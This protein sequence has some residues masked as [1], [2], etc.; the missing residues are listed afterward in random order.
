MK[1]TNRFFT[2][3]IVTLLLFS[4]KPVSAQD[5]DSPQRP[6]YITATTFHWNMDYKDFDMDTWKAVEKEYL[7][8][9]VKKN[10]YIMGYSVYLHY[11]TPD[12]SELVFVNVYGSWDD[13]DKAGDRNGELIR[14]GW[15]DE[16][17]RREFFQK[18]NAY[19]ADTHSDEIYAPMSGAK[20][21]A[22]APT[23]DVICY[24]RTSHFAFPSDGSGK[25]FT[26][27]RDS[28]IKNVI[29]K[30]EY[31]KAYYPNA[32]AWG[33]DRTQYVEAFYV[34]SLCDLDKMFDRNNELVKEAWP[35]EAARKEMGEKSSKYFTGVHGDAIYTYVHEL[36]K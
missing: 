24:V 35:D 18:R 19:Y 17:A 34:D 7:D 27:L 2:L 5:E 33:S 20:P 31:I 4:F 3:L 26:E 1:T 16:A 30:N 36:S 21:F 22:E 23:K 14:E 9:V 6:A 12:N 28:Y 10:E 32:H 8:K 25:E 29:D 15:P 13:I 11:F